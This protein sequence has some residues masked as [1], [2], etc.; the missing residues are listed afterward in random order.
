MDRLLGKVA[1][2]TGGA[3]GIGLATAE[4]FA[5]ESAQVVIA[6]RK[7]AKGEQAVRRIKEQTGKDARFIP[8]DVSKEKEVIDLVQ[9]VIDL[10]RRID[11][12]V[13]SAGVLLRTPF[14]EVTEKDWSE[15]MDTNLKGDFF[16]CKHALPRMIT[17]GR[18]SLINISSFLSL[19]GKSDNPLYTASKGGVMTLTRSLA[20]RHAR[21]HVRVN[22][23]CPGWIVTDMNRDA[24]EKAPD[25][26]R[27][28][29]ELESTYPLGR[30][31]EP[32]DVAY[33]AL[34]LASDESQWITGIAL[35]VDGGYSAGKE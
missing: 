14:E 5:R 18:G 29:K 16:C 15:I 12:W 9:N 34:Y 4:L 28:R 26:A 10:Y 22:C 3:S 25:P 13:N 7:A 27:K 31:G 17:H 6:S 23:I 30:L 2:I 11:I 8:C 24:I 20:M 1:V 33:A 32:T 21:H 35:P 19:I